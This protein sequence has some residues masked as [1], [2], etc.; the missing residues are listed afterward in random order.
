MKRSILVT[1]AA[2]FIGFHTALQLVKEGHK[3][4]GLDN[5]NSYYDPKLK[6][7]RAE[8]LLKV[9]VEVV[10]ADLNER[11]KLE[12]IVREVTDVIHLAAQAGVRYA[13][14]NPDAYIHSNINGFLSIL[15]TLRKFPH[16]KLLYASSSSVYGTNAKVP[17]SIEDR[18]DQPANLY[19]ATKK[20]NELMAYSYHTMFGLSC[21]G[22]RFFTVYG[23]WGRPDMAYFSF[24]NSILND[25]PIT[26]YSNGEMLRD[27]TYIDDVVAGILAALDHPASYALFNLG[28]N[29]PI[30]VLSLVSL[31]EKFLN[32]KAH[33]NLDPTSQGEVHTTYADIT[34]ALPFTPKT[35]LET[36]LSQFISWH[37]NY[38]TNS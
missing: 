33:L 34:Q 11:V 25:T 27:F 31:L 4:I 14:T 19:A 28:N 5:F 1:G 22:L 6:R 15:E 13:K 37:H 17:F 24:T 26:L 12:E 8:I 16:V 20:A 38:F 7:A 18:T 30:P 36:G 29:K 9:G 35:S 21:I 3:V 10:E 2:G 32:K 23:P